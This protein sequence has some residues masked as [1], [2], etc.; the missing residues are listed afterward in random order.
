MPQLSPGAV[1]MDVALTNVAIAYRQSAANFVASRV[2]PQVP[3]K[4]QSDKYWVFDRTDLN[5]RRMKKRAPATESAGTTLRLSDE[6]YFAEKWALHIDV[7][8]ETRDNADEEINLDAAVTESL[9]MAGLIEREAQ[10]AEE[11]MVP[12]VWDHDVEGVTAGV[13]AGELLVWNDAG[14]NPIADIRNRATLIQGTTGF[15]PNKLVLGQQVKDALVEHPDIID[16]IKY[17]SGNDKP[18]IV[19]DRALAALFEV[20]EVVTMAAVMNTGLEGAAENI[21]FIGGRNALLAYAPRVIVPNTPSAF[22][23]FNWTKYLGNSPQGIRTKRFR[24]EK[25]EA[26]RIEVEMFYDMKV[27]GADLGALFTDIVQDPLNPVSQ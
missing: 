25:I 11:F 2:V 27:T 23:M 6:P 14:S 7:A 13:G 15:R 16:R 22:A 1:H 10:F 9:T 24:M 20:D 12:S 19:N 26:D 18:A 5:R 4:K 8:D 17:T 3:V 21:E